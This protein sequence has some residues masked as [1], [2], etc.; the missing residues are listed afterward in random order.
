MIGI[1]HLHPVADDPS[2]L[3]RAEA[4]IEALR[5]RAGFLRATLG[6]AVD[7]PAE[8]VLLT[9][10]DSVGAYRRALGGFE[11]KLAATTL[12]AQAAD[13]PSA[14]ESLLTVGAD[15]TEVR[16]PSDRAEVWPRP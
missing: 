4:A 8:W 6:R 15:G 13:Q 5:V 11:V 1:V 10:W 9:E 7:D 2:F 3:V 14:F 12:L 16:R